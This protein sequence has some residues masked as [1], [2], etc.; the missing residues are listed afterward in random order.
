LASS[1]WKLM[2]GHPGHSPGWCAMGNSVMPAWC[3]PWCPV[4]LQ[5]DAHPLIPP[6]GSTRVLHGVAPCTGVL[7]R[8]DALVALSTALSHAR[9]RCQLW[10]LWRMGS[11]QRP[12]NGR[13]PVT[14]ERPGSGWD[15]SVTDERDSRGRWLRGH[16]GNR[17][18]R[19]K[20]SRNRWRR[21]DPARA[22][23][24]KN[25]EWRLHFARTMRTAQGDQVERAGAA[26]AACQRLWRAH[27]PRKTKSAMCAQCGLTLSPPKPSFGAAPI[28][29]DN[30]FVHH[31]CLCQFALSRW[32]E[33]RLAL[34]HLGIE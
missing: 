9:V 16:S 29:V 24:W 14:D 22:M 10:G 31:S 19:R 30:A 11:H 6:R 15:D 18:G 27:H 7:P 5:R 2:A 21:A 3:P 4:M 25:S 23:H 13:N 34:R 12:P 33:A 26:Y 28:Q 20:G 32:E 17:L 1:G 8:G